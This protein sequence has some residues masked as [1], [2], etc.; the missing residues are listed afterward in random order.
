VQENQ[1]PFR[2]AQHMFS[3]LIVQV[4]VW[5]V[6]VQDVV[7]VKNVVGVGNIGG[8]VEVARTGNG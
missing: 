1:L 3:G 2:A 8:V 7:G 4:C 5:K 6:D